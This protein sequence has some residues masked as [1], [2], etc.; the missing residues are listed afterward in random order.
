MI[1]E[2]GALVAP[3]PSADLVLVAGIEHVAAA[4]AQRSHGLPVNLEGD[5]DGW[6]RDRF[7]SR[8]RPGKNKPTDD[9]EKDRLAKGCRK[10][11]R[12]LEDRRGNSGGIR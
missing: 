1:R 3:Y 8:F 6:L 2:P 4:W 9:S 11:S 7:P 10:N 12:R 5:F